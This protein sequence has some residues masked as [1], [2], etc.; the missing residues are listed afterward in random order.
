VRVWDAALAATER[1]APEGHT[2][3]VTGCA[4]T[5][6]GD[7]LVSTGADDSVRLWAAD[8]ARPLGSRKGP[9]E[10]GH[11]WAVSHDLRRIV[12]ATGDRTAVW[13]AET[14]AEL[15]TLKGDT[16]YSGHGGIDACAFGPDERHL[17]TVHEDH[18]KVWDVASR[19]ELGALNEGGGWGGVGPPVRFSPDASLIATGGGLIPDDETGRRP[20]LRVWDAESRALL[21]ELEAD[22]PVI[23][24]P[25]GSRLL[26]SGRDRTLTMWDPATG[27]R[28]ASFELDAGGVD[29]CA[30]TPDGRWVVSVELARGLTL[31]D[32]VTG[33]VRALFMHTT[34]PTALALHPWLPRV[35]YG[36]S[37]GALHLIDLVG[38]RYGPIVV[39]P[40]DHGQGPT[41][42]CPACRQEIP[43]PSGATGAVTPCPRAGCGLE[44]RPNPFVLA[45]RRQRWHLGFRRKA[46]G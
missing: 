44:L 34:T 12:S 33:A 25:D 23:F 45:G 11:Q 38:L 40:V 43:L 1:P 4:F 31:R 35:V 10:Y 18:V 37:A 30:F 5:P 8:D 15:F 27:A 17:V 36:D 26:S 2:G 6:G 29:H 19:T 16:G 46:G 9:V 32:A 20:G 21:R 13:E 28:T 39:T 22:P 24:S 3:P 41:L 42:T 7:R 14:G